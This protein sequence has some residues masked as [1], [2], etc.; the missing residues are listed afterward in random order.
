MTICDLCKKDPIATAPNEALKQL[1][2]GIA[3]TPPAGSGVPEMRLCWV[4]T[5]RVF[6]AWLFEIDWPTQPES[7]K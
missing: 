4:C 1:P 6:E 2:W 7:P 5:L 3:L